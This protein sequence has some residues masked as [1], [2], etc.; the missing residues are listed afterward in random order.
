MS[1]ALLASVGGGKAPWR[2][3][4]LLSSSP[5]PSLPLP[6]PLPHRGWRRQH[7]AAL[8]EPWQVGKTLDSYVFV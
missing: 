5:L 4:S 6:Q 8:P 3:A 2:G 7:R 1:G